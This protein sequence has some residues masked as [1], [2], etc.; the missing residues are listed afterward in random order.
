MKRFGQIDTGS[1]SGSIASGGSSG[2]GITKAELTGDPS[3]DGLIGSYIWNNASITYNFPT[4]A[5]F[6]P[7]NYAEKKDFSAATDALQAAMQIVMANYSDVSLLTFTEVGASDKSAAVSIAMTVQAGDRAG[8]GYSPESSHGGDLWIDRDYAT[9]GSTFTRGTFDYNL[10]THEL[11]HTLGLKHPHEGSTTAPTIR[12]AHQFSVMSYYSYAG[13]TSGI[14]SLGSYQQSLMMDDIAALQHMYGANFNTRSGNTA[15]SFDPNTG[16][17][18]ID[19][20]G[21]GAPVINKIFLTIW[22]GGG[23]DTYDFSNYGTNLKV[24]LTPGGWSVLSTAQLADLADGHV[25]D[26]NVFNARL[27]DGDPRSLIEN[28]KGG[29]G[30]DMISG[31]QTRN[32]LYGNDGNDSLFGMGGED[33]LLGGRGDDVVRGGYDADS[34]FGEDGNDTLLGEDGFDFLVGGIGNDVL[35]GGVGNDT[36]NG[37]ANND[38]LFGDSGNDLLHGGEG[39]DRLVGGSGNDALYGST[40]H[41]TFYFRPGS[42]ADKVYDFTAGGSEDAIEL[43]YSSIDSFAELLAATHDTY[44]GCVITLDT[45]TSVTLVGVTKSQ[46]TAADLYVPFTVNFDD[47][48]MGT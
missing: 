9:S 28:V 10:L 8:T 20:I 44:N 18:F 31:N 19:G 42:G 29:S 11:G 37:N 16:E 38:R 34:V 27:F 48:V 40:G 15:Y 47:M 25:P 3:I 35:Y 2:P 14:N 13:A 32:E 5:S 7:D 36:L 1:L 24:D 46:L 43:G 17:M 4:K 23:Q 26:G 12:D 6:Y 30:A 33:L 22:D 39:A 21:Q 45:A 41:D